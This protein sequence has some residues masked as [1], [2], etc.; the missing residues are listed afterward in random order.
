MSENRVFQCAECKHT[1]QQE[2]GQLSL[3]CPECRGKTL[4]LLEGPSLKGAK[5]CGGNC[6]SCG[7]GCSCH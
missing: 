1:F 6:G 4:L 5:N 2:V 3:R 7:G